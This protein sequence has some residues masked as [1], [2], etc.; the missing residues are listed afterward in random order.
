LECRRVLIRSLYLSG[1][2][3][4][5]TYFGF[6]TAVFAHDHGNELW[7]GLG[8]RCRLEQNGVRLPKGLHA[9]NDNSL[10][11]TEVFELIRQQA[12]RFDSTFLHKRAAY[13]DVYERG[14]VYLYKLAWYLHFKEIVQRVTQPADTLYVIAGSLQTHNKRDAIRHALEDVCAQLDRKSVV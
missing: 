4:S 8:L 14:P 10:T 7:E 1:S 3:G 2:A 13:R 12:P 11:R 6:G 9:K 5:S